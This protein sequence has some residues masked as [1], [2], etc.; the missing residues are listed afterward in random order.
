MRTNAWHPVVV[1]DCRSE[2][3]K[4][5]QVV[6]AACVIVDLYDGF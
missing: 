3:E 5:E 6:V 1:K 4:R 2:T